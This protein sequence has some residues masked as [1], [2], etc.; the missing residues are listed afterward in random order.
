LKPPSQFM[1]WADQ[2]DISYLAWSWQPISTTAHGCVSNNLSLLSTWQSS[3]PT[4][5]HQVGPKVESHLAQLA[6]G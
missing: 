2:H 6:A 1:A 3:A 5:T 4:R